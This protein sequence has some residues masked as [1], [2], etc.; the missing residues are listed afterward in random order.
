MSKIRF[1]V[2][3]DIPDLIEEIERLQDEIKLSVLIN[4][5]LQK[6]MI[7]NIKLNGEVERRK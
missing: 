6:G 4:T 1:L 2:A 3:S 5:G 7:E